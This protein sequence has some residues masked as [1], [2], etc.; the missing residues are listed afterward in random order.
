MWIAEFRESSKSWT[1]IAL[2][3]TK[4][5]AWLSVGHKYFLT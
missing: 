4:E 3:V 2:F 1:Q 5:C